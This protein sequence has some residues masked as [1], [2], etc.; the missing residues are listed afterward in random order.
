MPIV[1]SVLGKILEKATLPFSPQANPSQERSGIISL[2]SQVESF[3]DILLL[4]PEYLH[5]SF[6]HRICLLKPSPLSKRGKLEF[7]L[8]GHMELNVLL[9]R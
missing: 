9:C 6:S 7:V 3:G 5:S 4:L 2:G 8:Q 1:G